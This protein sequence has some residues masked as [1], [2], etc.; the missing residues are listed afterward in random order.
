MS[1][2]MHLRF[3]LAT[4]LALGLLACPQGNGDD[5]DLCGNGV[6]D[7]G[8]GCDGE[9]LGGQVCAY[10]DFTHGL[11]LCDQSCA[12]DTSQCL[13]DPCWSYSCEAHGYGP[14]AIVEDRLFFPANGSAREMDGGDDYLSFG[15]I[16]MQNEAHGC[17]LKGLML[18][19][20]A[21]W[22]GYCAEEA[23]YLEALYQEMRPQGIMLVG[24]VTETQTGA[25]AAPEYAAQYGIDYGWTFPTV[26]G[27]LPL[28]FWEATDDAGAVP[29][30]LFVD[31]RNM[32][33]AGRL[34]GLGDAKL[35]RAALQEL[36]DGPEWGPAGQRIV[37]FD[38]APDSGTE[39]EPNGIADAPESAVSLPYSL[40]GVFCPPVI[41]EGIAIDEDVVDLGNLAAGT[42]FEV[43]M[44]PLGN[45]NT[46]PFFTAL[47][48]NS[49]GTQLE[50]EQYGPGVM[51]ATERRHVWVVEEAGHHLLAL[52]DGR[53]IS[54]IFYGES[55]R[56]PEA[57][58]CCEG[59]PEHT[60]ELEVRPLDLAA[61]EAA[62][63]VG[64]SLNERLAND[65]PRIYPLT[66]TSGTAYTIQ[67]GSSSYDL[68]DPYL[69]LYDPLTGSTLAFNDDADYA[70]GNRGSEITWTASADQTVLIVAT[71][72]WA[73][74]RNGAPAYS[75]SVQ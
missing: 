27:E 70:G 11:L 17:D 59:G 36:A 41:A 42:A 58:S 31:L 5:D 66:V 4:L 37:D 20:S 35:L 56:P 25:R 75:L 23:A 49:S 2:R 50:W 60:Y 3:G 24:L 9:E 74:F 73:F 30:H 68:L 62:V 54:G 57:H 38:C 26:S 33:L 6:I 22:C 51:A 34:S 32:R 71:Y 7:E 52:Y 63:S 53:L 48:L 45:T 13:I 47:R 28:A 1:I 12:L 46:F 18:F 39:T 21:G 67:M 8:E 10:H 40:S 65:G 15:D 43:I 44:R 72:Y 61:T 19:V 16:Y 69:L 14:G 64:A 29:F 55:Y